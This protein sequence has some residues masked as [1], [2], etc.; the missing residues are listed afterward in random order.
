MH[1][2]GIKR[3]VDNMQEI[4]ADAEPLD[5][6]QPRLTQRSASSSVGEVGYL[7]KL[8]NVRQS[9]RGR[10][11]ELDPTESVVDRERRRQEE[12]QLEMAQQQQR[13]QIEKGVEKYI[14]DLRGQIRNGTLPDDPSVLTAFGMDDD[15]GS[16]QPEDLQASAV[17]DSLFQG[18]AAQASGD[19]V[20]P[21]QDSYLEEYVAPNAHSLSTNDVRVQKQLPIN[22][23]SGYIEQ[24]Y[25][26]DGHNGWPPGPQPY[27]SGLGALARSPTGQPGDF[28]EG[29]Q[30]VP[31]DE[32]PTPETQ[33]D[34]A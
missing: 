2:E 9:Q 11:Q 32:A 28:N 15:F 20:T 26:P 19:V 21:Q 12:D 22:R 14:E 23:T 27:A 24:L 10:A 18:L 8:L 6:I 13:A 31:Y 16:D 33:H 17:D 4:I 34:E 29:S 3:A 1:E 25:I 7:K 5:S 30:D